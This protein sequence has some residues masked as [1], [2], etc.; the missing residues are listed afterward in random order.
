MWMK[1]LEN[2][3]L[4]GLEQKHHLEECPLSVFWLRRAAASA[5]MYGWEGLVQVPCQ[6]PKWLS[7]PSAS[8]PG[9]R[10]TGTGWW[11]PCIT[12]L[13]AREKVQT[14]DT[15]RIPHSDGCSHFDSVDRR[16]RALM[17]FCKTVYL[18]HISKKSAPVQLLC[19]VSLCWVHSFIQTYVCHAAVV[20][21]LLKHHPRGRCAPWLQRIE[22]EP[23]YPV[24][25]TDTSDLGD[26]Q[27]QFP[28]GKL[29]TRRS[30]LQ[31]HSNS[32]LKG[33]SRCF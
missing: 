31:S 11:C 18:E 30:D 26:L 32:N 15:E 23:A 1:A 22:E 10:T 8:L 14:L 24:Q 7:A 2:L 25:F 29:Q 13:S 9:T 6:C 28:E 16:A 5:K 27:N 12:L 3:S 20:H 19:Q 4:N 17:A 21:N 33:E